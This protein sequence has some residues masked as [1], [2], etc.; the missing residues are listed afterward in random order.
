MLLTE[1][2]GRPRPRTVL[3]AIIGFDVD[4]EGDPIAI[5]S[6]G[7]PQHVRHRPP[8]IMRAWV[9]TEEGRRSMLGER[10][11]CVRCERFELPMH[12]VVHRK[13]RLLTERD[14]E[15]RVRLHRTDS[16]IW[17]R[18]TVLD[19]RVRYASEMPSIDVVL[20]MGARA[21]VVPEAAY[22]VEPLGRARFFI[23][24]LRAPGAKG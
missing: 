19:G 8:F 2:A 24:Y 9:T 16:G 1:E 12:F 21:V 18:I 4:A 22:R 10:L 7:H 5:L 6:C 3:R 20:G 23:E 13:T 15:G 17:A 14:I 11:N